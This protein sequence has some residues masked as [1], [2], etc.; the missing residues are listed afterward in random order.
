[1]EDY[2]KSEMEGKSLGA[3]DKKTNR[4]AQETDE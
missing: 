2:G 3:E 1:L 4:S